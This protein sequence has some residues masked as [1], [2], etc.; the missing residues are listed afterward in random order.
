MT[1]QQRGEPEWLPSEGAHQPAQVESVLTKWVG[2][3]IVLKYLGSPE[4]PLDK[5]DPKGL[6]RTAVEARSGIFY[7]HKYG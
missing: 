4:K 3:N 7:L 6:A 1:Q 5:Q 2:K